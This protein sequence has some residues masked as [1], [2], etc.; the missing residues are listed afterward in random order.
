MVK[1]GTMVAW[2]LHPSPR[3]RKS[4]IIS[5]LVIIAL[6]LSA[7]QML[8]RSFEPVYHP[9]D[10]K[11]EAR[12]LLEKLYQAHRGSD[13]EMKDADTATDTD[14]NANVNGKGTP[15]TTSVPPDPE[16]PYLS[17]TVLNVQYRPIDVQG[18]LGMMPFD[19]KKNY[20]KDQFCPDLLYKSSD[21]K[22]IMEN[23]KARLLPDDLEGLNEYLRKTGYGSLFSRK[24]NDFS[25]DADLSE[26]D[27]TSYPDW[28]RF[29]G[30]SVWLPDEKVHLM[31][32][33]LLYAPA[34]YPL[35]SFIR[36][37]IFDADWNEIKGRRL[38]YVDAPEHDIKEAM[39]NYT[40]SHNEEDLDSVSIKF[41]GILDIDLDEESREFLL[42]PEDPRIVYNDVSGIPEPVIIFNQDANGGRAMY[43]TFPLERTPRGMKK[44]TLKLR[45]ALMGD[46]TY[47][48]NWT[49]FFDTLDPK[50]EANMRGSMYVMYDINPLRVYKCSLDSGECFIVQQEGAKAPNPRGDKLTSIRGGTSLIPIPRYVVQRLLRRDGILD[51]DYPLQMW[52][53]F[54]KTHINDCG[55]GHMFY[56]PHLMVM[57]KQEHSFRVDLLSDSMDFGKD[58]MSFDDHSSVYC[59]DGNN[60]LN[61]NEIAFWD[62]SYERPNED[63]VFDLESKLLPYYDD[64]LALTISEADENVQVIFLKNVLNYIIGAYKHGTL[65]LGKKD[66]GREVRERTKKVESCVLKAASRYCEIYSL[67][68][69][70]PPPETI[71]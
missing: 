8:N 53:G 2:L 59:D 39:G 70:R 42:G 29:T 60:V 56:R 11:D 16:N 66:V 30:S 31:A 18:F 41:P 13:A 51:S 12:S 49:P 40:R 28:F 52:L 37:Q 24:H 5:A 22:R 19:P 63:S 23:S 3:I 58:V 47:E 54:V 55:C 36:L 43:L 25:P 65:V 1:S 33:R 69:K 6:V 27:F 32:S 48:K 67:T 68:H 9:L 64:Y 26:V 44:P 20:Y 15:Q 35:M 7:T 61:P 17:N 57:V 21:S 38:L 50:P 71:D 62:I 4:I 46:G 14:T 10:I 34:K 45:T